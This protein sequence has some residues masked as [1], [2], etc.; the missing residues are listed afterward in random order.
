MGFR[1]ID[2][3]LASWYQVSVGSAC[4][5]YFSST[6]RKFLF[7]SFN[8]FSGVVYS[9]LCPCFLEGW[10]YYSTLGMA[11]CPNLTS[12]NSLGLL[13][14]WV[15]NNISF[16]IIIYGTFART[17]QKTNLVAS[18]SSVC[19]HMGTACLRTKSTWRK[20]EEWRKETHSWW[21]R[22]SSCIYPCSESLSLTFPS[23]V[24]QWTA[25]PFC[26][27]NLIDKFLLQATECSGLL[28]LCQS[29]TG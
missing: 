6:L 15:V 14:G 10:L 11:S 4:K 26:L 27:F 24:I 19:Y 8:F 20:T 23:S 25:P 1:I 9:Q 29:L 7:F 21:Q 2:S 3:I 22:S 17:P 16:T 5:H 13:H 12:Q 28:L 18:R